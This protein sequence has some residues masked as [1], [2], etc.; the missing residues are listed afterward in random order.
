MIICKVAGS[1]VSTIKNERFEGKKLLIVQPL[2]LD[3]K[4]K[5]LSFNDRIV[6]RPQEAGCQLV[7][8]TKLTLWRKRIIN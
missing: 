5:G 4:E 6:V 7:E 8:L 2:D 3:L 1:I